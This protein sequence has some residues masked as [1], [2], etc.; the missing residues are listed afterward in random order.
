MARYIKANYKVAQYLHLESV[1]NRV[2]DGNYLLWQADMLAF[3]RLIDLPQ[4]LSKIGAIS[5]S[6]KEAKEEQDGTIVREL[7]TAEDETFVI[8]FDDV[9]Q[10]EDTAT[11]DET[12]ETV[13]EEP[14]QATEEEPISDKEKET[15]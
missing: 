15:E 8:E 6:A 4:I 13:T 7:P 2:T 3:G 9:K 5:L 11:A 14:E 1:R 10:E 12:V